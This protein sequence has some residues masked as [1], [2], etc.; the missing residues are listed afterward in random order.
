MLS[1]FR[2][3]QF[4][5]LA[6]LSIIICSN[7]QP[8]RA[9]CGSSVSCVCQSQFPDGSEFNSPT[10]VLVRI[11]ATAVADG[12]LQAELLEV[13]Q[14]DNTFQLEPGDVLG[15]IGTTSGGA[16]SLITGAPCSNDRS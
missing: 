8:A 14:P 10:G 6:A 1:F 15:R 5:R 4:F 16:G 3:A 11:R 9:D 12:F 7:G 2:S 13:V